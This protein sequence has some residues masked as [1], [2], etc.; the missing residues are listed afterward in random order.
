MGISYKIPIMNWL[1]NP[2]VITWL[3]LIAF[4]ALWIKRKYFDMAAFLP[5]FLNRMRVPV[6]TAK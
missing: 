2:G 6:I 1:Y 5:V 4:F 3:I